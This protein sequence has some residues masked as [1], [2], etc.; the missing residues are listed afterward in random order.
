MNKIK[1]NQK[2]VQVYIGGDLSHT[3]LHRPICIECMHRIC[4]CECLEGG[5]GVEQ[6]KLS[7]L[8]KN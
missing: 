2:H 5:G 6:G 3:C 7:S 8:N 1:E 4:V